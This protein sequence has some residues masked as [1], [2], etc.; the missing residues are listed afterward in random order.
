MFSVTE[1]I[2]Q[3]KG[4]CKGEASKTRGHSDVTLNAGNLRRLKAGGS[5]DWPPHNFS[6]SR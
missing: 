5:Q 3:A 6:Q 2:H 1:I 4:T